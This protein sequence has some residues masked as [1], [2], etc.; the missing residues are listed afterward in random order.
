MHL[1]IAT[2]VKPTPV[3]GTP[4]YRTTSEIDFFS[5]HHCLLI[6]PIITMVRWNTNRNAP[7][8]ADAPTA[9]CGNTQRLRHGGFPCTFLHFHISPSDLHW[10]KCRFRYRS[11]AI[12]FQKVFPSCVNNV[13]KAKPIRDSNF[14]ATRN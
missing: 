5:R 1:D 10:G 7:A 2:I 9:K 13:R 3:C 6:Q 8:V 14:R 12:G 11:F 4:I